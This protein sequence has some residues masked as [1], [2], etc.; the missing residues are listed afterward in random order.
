M[1]LPPVIKDLFYT[2]SLPSLGPEKRN[3]SLGLNECEDLI[4][5][6]LK[7]P[8]TEHQALIRSALLLWHDHL[9]ASHEISQCINSKDGSFLH[10]LMHRREPD[11]PNAKYWLNQTGQYKAYSEIAKRSKILLKEASL[12]KLFTD[13]WNPYAMVDSVEQT[14]PNTQTYKTLQKIQQIEMEIFIETK[15]S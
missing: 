3:D 10:A 6:A 15:C 1:P 4:G 11:F 14:N 9:E 7:F 8:D 2:N 5:S 12:S 13:E